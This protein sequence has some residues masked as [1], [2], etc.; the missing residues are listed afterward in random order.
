M[1]PGG[2]ASLGG[3]GRG[4]TDRLGGSSRGRLSGGGRGDQVAV[5]AVNVTGVSGGTVL[6]IVIATVVIIIIH[7]HISGLALSPLVPLF[8]TVPRIATCEDQ[9][10]LTL[11]LP[12]D[13]QVPQSRDLIRTK[14]RWVAHHHSIGKMAIFEKCL[15]ALG[16]GTPS[17]A[18]PSV[19]GEV[20]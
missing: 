8:S 6:T 13:P 16:H 17:D 2:W 10:Y 18:R 14:M 20:A 3:I 19:A 7:L 4:G 1:C 9:S 5:V 15:R 11:L 12:L